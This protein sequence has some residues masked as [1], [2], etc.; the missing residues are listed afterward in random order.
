[1]YDAW[2]ECR[3]VWPWC[4][5]DVHKVQTSTGL[6]LLGVLVVGVLLLRTLYVLGLDA[7]GLGGSFRLLLLDRLG[8]VDLLLRVG[9]TVVNCRLAKRPL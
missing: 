6:L 9:D 4:N 1:M 5:H 8:V 2:L 3:S 7:R